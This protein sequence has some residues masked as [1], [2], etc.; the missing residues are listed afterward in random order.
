M[1]VVFILYF[2]VTVFAYCP[3][4]EIIIIIIIIIV[5]VIILLLLQGVLVF[6]INAVTMNFEMIIT[7][8]REL[9][10]ILF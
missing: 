8:A 5:I 10:I 1:F 6:I 3:V 4:L 9:Y 7:F 2:D